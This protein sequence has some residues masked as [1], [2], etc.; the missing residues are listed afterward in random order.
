VAQLR[1]ADAARL[2]DFIGEAQTV[3]G[4][5]PFTTDVLALLAGVTGSDSVAYNEFED[6]SRS[7]YRTQM[8]WDSEQWDSEQWDSK[9]PPEEDW[10]TSVVLSE[11]ARTHAGDVVV[12]SDHIDRSSRIRFETV[13][14]AEFFG[15]VDQ[16]HVRMWSGVS[17]LLLSSRERDF[18]TRDRLI[19]EA[20]RPHAAALVRHARCRRQ[21]ST[22]QAAV[23][24]AEKSDARGFAVIGSGE[25]IE[26]ASP[27]AQRLLAAWFGKSP[28]GR[29]PELIR[30][31][32]RSRSDQ[33]LRVER[34]GTRLVV[35]TP[36]RGALILVEERARPALTAREVEVLRA[37]AAGKST[38]EIARDL[39]VAPSTVSKHLEHV[40]RKL[41][42]PNRTAAL[43][44]MGARVDALRDGV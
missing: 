37:L 10:V 18:T 21:L 32:L 25:V 13:P 16:T 14:W 2:L 36:T 42:V 23:E 12:W 29:V 5:E 11:F 31:W 22:L 20:L 15:L 6:G 28:G 39:Y 44:A 35:E 24:T 3:E 41:G 27:P 19:A 43:A 26:Y 38:A 8:D 7:A 17:V 33:P 30:D 9:P 1:G 34:N 40:Y 4:P